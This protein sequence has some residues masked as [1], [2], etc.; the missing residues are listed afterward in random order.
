MARTVRGS[1]NPEETG[2]DA[3]CAVQSKNRWECALGSS[4]RRD[5]LHQPNTNGRDGREDGT[6][7]PVARPRVSENSLDVAVLHQYDRSLSSN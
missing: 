1:V 6:L 3:N 2:T 4:G 7:S 5:P